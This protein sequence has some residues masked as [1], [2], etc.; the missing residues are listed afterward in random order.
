MEGGRIKERREREK[1][2][3]GGEDGGRIKGGE[4]ERGRKRGRGGTINSR[5]VPEHFKPPWYPA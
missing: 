4:R 3:E 5:A 1:E 2:R